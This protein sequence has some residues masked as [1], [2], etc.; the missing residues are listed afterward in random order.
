MN[1]QA[2]RV[3]LAV[4]WLAIVAVLSFGAAGIVASMSHPPGTGSR[5]ELTY[6]GDAAI[7]PGLSA[8]ENELNVLSGQV[9]DLSDLG[10]TALGH[11][12]ASNS[13]A[14]DATVADGEQL[15]ATIETHSAQIRRQLETLPGLGPTQD[16]YLSPE[17]RRR[18]ALALSALDATNGLQ[19]A[20][21]RLAVSSAAASRIT[22]LLTTHDKT[23]GEAV[24]AGREERYADALALLDQSDQLMAQSRAFRDTLSKTVDV[25]TLTDW[26]D[27]NTAYDAAVRRLYQALVDSKGKVTSE[28]RK[29][30]D[31]EIA[32]RK[33]L[34]SDSK[35][36]VIILAE[37]G[38]GGLNQAVIT[39]EQARGELD[40]ALAQLHGVGSG[41]PGDSGPV[42]SPS[43]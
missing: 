10:R 34:P 33:L 22:T 1:G 20:W 29:A 36:L 40:S 42:E 35:G 16:L 7:E 28:V 19:A 24:V 14:L 4:A 17:V 9:A 27:L 26:L 23:T 6:A 39:I 31:G 37:I 15:A 25:G 11:L 18:Q 12:T 32:A 41:A 3:A 8:A 5:A 13:D 43:S 38:R 30:F 2:R 21:S